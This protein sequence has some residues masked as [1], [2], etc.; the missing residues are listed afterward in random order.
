MPKVL[1]IQPFHADG[2]KLLE[3]RSDVVCEV[4]DGGL[5]E[6]AEKIRMPTA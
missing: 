5:E 3:A 1:I 2:M 6:L 4:V